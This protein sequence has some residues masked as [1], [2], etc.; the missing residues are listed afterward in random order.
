MHRPTK[1]VE[2]GLTNVATGMWKFARWMDARNEPE[3]SF[4]PDWTE[5]PMLKSWEKSK[6]ALGWPVASRPIPN[7]PQKT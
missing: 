5:K 4:T 7:R 1:Y 6:P 3:P 2:K